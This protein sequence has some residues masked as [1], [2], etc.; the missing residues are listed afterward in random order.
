MIRNWIYGRPL[1]Q[2]LLFLVTSIVIIAIAIFAFE[3]SRMQKKIVL[4]AYAR[5]T[6]IQLEA[7]KLGLEIGLKEENYQS[8]DEVLS[9][10]W[11]NENLDYMLLT[12]EDGEIIAVYP[13]THTVNLAEVMSLPTSITQNEINFMKSVSWYSTLTGESSLY[14]VYN[15]E[16][17]RQ[18]EQ[19]AVFKIS[20][21]A[22][23]LI[24]G[25]AVSAF[26]VAQG[27][28]KPIEALQEVTQRISSESLDVRVDENAG[29]L[30]LK[31]VAASFNTMLDTLHSTQTKRF[32]EMQRFNDSL[33]KQ[34][35]ELNKAYLAL[36]EQSMQLA[37][38]S[39][40][41]TNALEDLK[42]A[43]VKL[44][45]SEKMASLGQLVASVAHELNTPSG[46]INGAIN[47]INR[48]YIEI[49]NDVVTLF[50]QLS[51]TKSLLY[52]N[53][54]KRLIGSN[55]DLSTSEIRELGKNITELINDTGISD[56]RHHSKMLAQVGF[57]VELTEQAIPLFKTDHAPK[58]VRSLHNIGMSRIHIRDIQIAIS[59][60]ILLVKALKTYSR[61]DSESVGLTDLAH[62]LNNTL[63]ILHNK[64]KRAITVHKDF[65]D[66][67]KVKCY[68]GKLNQVWT[69]LIHNSIQAMKGSG[70]IYLRL[71]K[72]DEKH[73]FVEV[74]DNGPGIDDEVLPK[75]FDPYFTTKDMGEGT[76]LGLSIVKD[77][78][79][80][81]NGTI[82]VE[83][84]PGKTIFRVT[85]P[86]LKDF[87]PKATM[88]EDG[89]TAYKY[90]DV[91]KK[92]VTND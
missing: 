42:N 75:I 51:S 67:P 13:D 41:A 53:I 88:T 62:D 77:I 40:K 24:I 79:D 82:Q 39:E 44:I 45:Q 80:S 61:I 86:I 38:E 8:I 92:E 5:S 28:T 37:E 20:L 7:V 57:S 11:Q 72:L 12:D 47:E 59:R 85:L 48:D 60:I 58:I 9:W 71:K 14:I 43:Q 65:D 74:E 91:Q 73:L 29:S 19:E 36:E 69:N 56:V 52:L 83:T 22:I 1:R 50:D 27:I 10:A 18:T 68:P 25:T 21:L 16:Y 66:L 26:L 81:H 87:I 6:Q 64:I 90:S 76:G 30:E 2:Q 23:I 15:T 63:I 31:T 35:L 17:L 33:E 54:I 46:A 3:N 49:M 89:D 55:S 84:N 78:I 32:E 34:N 70:T 4:D